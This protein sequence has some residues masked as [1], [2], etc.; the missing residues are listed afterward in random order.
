[1][2]Y[3][4]PEHFT[5]GVATAA[6][7]IAVPDTSD[8]AAELEDLRSLMM[9]ELKNNAAFDRIKADNIKESMRNALDSRI[10]GYR[11]DMEKMKVVLESNDPGLIMKRGYSIVKDTDGKVIT[12]A[13][14][15][16]D[17]QELEVDLASGKLGVKTLFRKE[18]GSVE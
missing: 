9:R 6:A 18:S 10:T 16:S 15:V 12:D 13:A 7:Q 17:G 14:Q 2:R 5:W 8:L 4:F 1:M 11:S 3:Q